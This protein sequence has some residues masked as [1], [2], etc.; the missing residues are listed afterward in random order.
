VLTPPVGRR[1]DRPQEHI[2]LS[3]TPGPA[4]GAALVT[5]GRP[6]ARSVLRPVGRFAF[7]RTE[8][9]HIEWPLLSPVD[10][11]EV[12]LLDSRGQPLNAPIVVTDV[13]DP[14]PAVAADLV[15]GAL[16]NGD[17]VLEISAQAAETTVVRYVAFRVKP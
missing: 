2:V 12:R 6:G 9:V 3:A 4:L 15:L 8:R 11:R 17:Y 1:P 16:G 14:I 13:V 7:S 5:R 10:R